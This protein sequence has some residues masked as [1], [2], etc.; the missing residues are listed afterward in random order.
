MKARSRGQALVEFALVLPIFLVL[1]FGMIDIGR[2]VWAND[3]LA[4][5]ARE[6]ARWA[7]VHGNWQFAECQTGPSAGTSP[8]SQCTPTTPDYKEATRE[9]VRGFLVAPG[10]AISDVT[11]QICYF[12][13][14]PCSGDSDESGATNKRGAFVT[15]TVSST[16]PI[17]TSRLLGMTSFGVSS[18]STVIINN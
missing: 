4:N 8:P 17:I 14:N 1:L 6:G 3:D 15:V 2:V 12:I 18:A 11:I 10:G 7:S 16:V 5:A 9:H 13:T